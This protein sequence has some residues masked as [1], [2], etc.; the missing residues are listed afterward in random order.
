MRETMSTTHTSN[1]DTEQHKPA[2]HQLS[3]P[4][5]LQGLSNKSATLK[6]NLRKARSPVRLDEIPLDQVKSPINVSARINQ[7]INRYKSPKQE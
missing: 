4:K 1:M 7:A 5:I 6:P 3:V 2:A